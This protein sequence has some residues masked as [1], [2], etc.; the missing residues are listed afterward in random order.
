MRA[1]TMARP[2]RGP[3]PAPAIQALLEPFVAATVG[4]GDWLACE[5]A[6]VEVVVVVGDG[7]VGDVVV[8][9]VGEGTGIPISRGYSIYR[10][11]SLKGS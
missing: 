3:I 8:D 11:C 2:A 9:R 7:P 1:E 6:V 5:S 4:V 10:S